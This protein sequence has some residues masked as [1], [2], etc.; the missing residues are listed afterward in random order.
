MS[1]EGAGQTCAL[2]SMIPQFEPQFPY[3]PK[4]SDNTL[5]CRAIVR[6]TDYT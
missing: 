5:L 2:Q 1:G 6:L 3:Q 4:G